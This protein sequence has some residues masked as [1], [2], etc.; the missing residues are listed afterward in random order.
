M[1][2]VEKRIRDGKVTWL[3]RWRDPD[4]RQ[5]KR[6]F[7]RRIEAERFVTRLAADLLRGDYVDPNDPTT[8]RE[9]AGLWRGAQ[10][11]GP[12][13]QAH[14]E[15]NLRRHVYPYFGERRLATIRPT[16]VQAWIT[17]LAANLAA[18]T[19]QVIHGIVAA[20]FK[21]AIRDRRVSASPCDSTT[22]PRKL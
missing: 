17:R 22:L 19:V 7:K 6:S 18:A 16:E 5:R 2:S 13:T 8:F 12:T 14:I 11:H 9:Y 20:I 3:A 4:R 1:A 10:V 21:A 15:T